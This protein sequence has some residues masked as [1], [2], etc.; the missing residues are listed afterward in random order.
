MV[1]RRVENEEIE[2][3]STI[4][5]EEL[6]PH[7]NLL[8]T[9]QPRSERYVRVCSWCSLVGSSDGKWLPVEEAVRALDLMGQ[10]DLPQLS[11]TICPSCKNVMLAPHGGDA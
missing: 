10:D 7:V 8:D 11:H 3:E 4:L 9:L 6:R 5:W 1:I 2:F